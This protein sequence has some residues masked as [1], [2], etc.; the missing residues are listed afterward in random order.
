VAGIIM[1]NSYMVCFDVK[2]YEFNQQQKTAF[3]QQQRGFN[4][5]LFDSMR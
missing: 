5:P 3:N 1:I 4:R 2:G